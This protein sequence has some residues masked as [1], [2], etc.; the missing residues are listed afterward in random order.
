L[1]FAG[2]ISQFFK[3]A[4]QFQHGHIIKEIHRVNVRIK[5]LLLL[6]STPLAFIQSFSKQVS[7]SKVFQA[8]YFGYIIRILQNPRAADV[9]SSEVCSARHLIYDIITNYRR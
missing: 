5:I 7:Y 3:K 8:R 9:N 2:P 6:I 4:L 1:V